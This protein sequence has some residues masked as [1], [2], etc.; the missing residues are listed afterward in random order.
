MGFV[1]TGIST[2]TGGMIDE[3]TVG[4]EPNSGKDNSPGGA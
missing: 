1:M 4:A 2:D 3:T